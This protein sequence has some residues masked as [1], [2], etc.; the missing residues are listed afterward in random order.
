MKGGRFFGYRVGSASKGAYHFL[1]HVLGAL[2]EDSG[3]AGY[4]GC[5]VQFVMFSS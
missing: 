2:D 5:D 3:C 1:E 4:G